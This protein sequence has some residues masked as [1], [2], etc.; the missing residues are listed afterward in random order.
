MNV[1]FGLFPPLSQVP[2]KDA[3][4]NRLRGPAKTIAKKRAMSARA[5]ADL[6]HWLGGAALAPAAE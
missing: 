4:G 1:N 2:N 6:E 5:L 3:D